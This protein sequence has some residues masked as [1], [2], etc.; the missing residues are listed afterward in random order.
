MAKSSARVRQRGSIRK[1]GNSYQ[2]RVSAGVDPLTGRELR[3]VES[4]PTR[5]P[6]SGS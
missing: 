1:R 5:R 2:V 4:Q 6:R 3:L